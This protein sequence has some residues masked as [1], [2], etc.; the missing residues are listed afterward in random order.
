MISSSFCALAKGGTRN[1]T[2]SRCWMVFGF[3]VRR[4]PLAEDP[5]TVV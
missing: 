5:N 4:C 1:E 3:D 2:E